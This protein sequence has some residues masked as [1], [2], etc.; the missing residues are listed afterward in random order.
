MPGDRRVDSI[1]RPLMAADDAAD[2]DPMNL[3]PPPAPPAPPGAGA[4]RPPL[5]APANAAL[6]TGPDGAELVV[7]IR[8]V[9][10]RFGPVPAL[11]DL[12][13]LVPKSRI[14]VLLGPNGAGKTT[15][16]R[17]I[18]GALDPDRGHVR[19]FGHDP[20]VFGEQVRRRCG[21]V[22]AKPALYD[23][24][25]GWDNLEYSAELYGLGRNAVGP[26]REAAARFGILE[27]LDQQVG[28]YSTGMKTRLALARSVL[29]EPD[30]LLFDEPTSGL[31][32]E[33]SHAVL[34]LI[35]EMT[36]DGRTVVMCTHLLVEAEGLADQVVILESGTDLLAGPQDELLRRYWPDHLVVLDA[37]NPMALDRVADWPGVKAYRRDGRVEVQLDD[38]ARV[39]DL[40]ARLAVEGVRLTRVEPHQPSLEE[41]YF[42]VRR[43]RRAQG[44]E[45]PL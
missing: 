42:A 38:L 17:V 40:V 37:E 8:G 24:L 22:S 33:S 36:T 10:R 9:S 19:T 11:S 26:I 21:V 6:G 12:T 14:T 28:G 16:I 18:T 41:L 34:E 5:A 1:L 2:G 31:D 30:L 13:L 3:P 45:A 35:R 43:E 20:N 44:V 15:A 7:E 39:P 27:A 29:H 32:P 4:H 25:S 23:R